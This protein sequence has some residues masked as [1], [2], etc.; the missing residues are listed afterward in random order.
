MSRGAGAA[1]FGP[2]PSPFDAVARTYDRRFTQ[3]PLGR[4]LRA[5]V[6]RHLD[7][8]FA[9]G[10]SVLDLGC[11]TGAD[12][13]H[14]ALRGVD[15][16]AVDA[17]AAMLDV[18]RERIAAAGVADRVRL[19]HA[20]IEALRRMGLA[21]GSLDGALANFG[22]L[23]AIAP[24]DLPLLGRD[25]GRCVRGNG[26]FIAVVMGPLCAW[27]TGWYLARRDPRRAFRRWR[28]G[29]VTADLGAGPF[30]VRYPSVRT[31]ARAAAPSFRLD[32]AVAV[33]CVVPPTYAGGWLVE[34][35]RLLRWLTALDC[36]IAHR[37]LAVAFA[38]HYLARL[39]RTP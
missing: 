19:V 11:G 36:R 14:L 18:A 23:N 3:H 5:A 6:W 7:A 25:L 17:S 16:V 20:P 12:A 38:D 32:G 35:P 8:A 26:A 39:G 13:V 30:T 15:V 21:S 4:T 24:A 2:L 34:R 29:G 37:S 1:P 31:L 27:E 28:R 22:S 10:A 9:P 33:G